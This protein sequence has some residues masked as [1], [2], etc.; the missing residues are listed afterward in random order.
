MTYQ[1]PKHFIIESTNLNDVVSTVESGFELFEFL[2]VGG[3]GTRGFG[4]LKIFGI[5]KKQKKTEH[6]SAM[7]NATL[8]KPTATAR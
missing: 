5:D 8:S 3:M 6:K 7:E 1:N 4:K 2:G